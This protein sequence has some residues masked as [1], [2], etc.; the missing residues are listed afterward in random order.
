MATGVSPW[1]LYLI[2][3]DAT[4]NVDWVPTVGDID[5]DFYIEGSEYCKMDFPANFVKQFYTGLKI[6]D[7]ANATSFIMK[8][9]KRGYL[10]TVYG[11]CYTKASADY[12]DEMLMS[13]AHVKAS[14]Y[15]DYYLVLVHAATVY[16]KFTDDSGTRQN[17]LQCG[18]LD[19]RIK[20]QNQGS[21]SLVWDV[22][23]T[24]KSAFR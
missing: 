6:T 22:N 20:H 14:S 4:T 10:F 11:K 2:E 1:T 13:N 3:S 8:K 9:G 18:I 17:Y 21:K 16:E 12:I 5:L 23:L 15:E 7:L 19:G 24:V